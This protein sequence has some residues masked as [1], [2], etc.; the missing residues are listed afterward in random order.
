MWQWEI[1]WHLKKVDTKTSY[2]LSRQENWNGL[3]TPLAV[4]AWPRC[5]FRALCAEAEAEDGLAKSGVTTSQ[6]GQAWA[7]RRPPGLLAAARA[8][9]GLYVRLLH[10]LG[11]Y[12]AVLRYGLRETWDVSWVIGLMF[13]KRESS[14]SRD[15]KSCSCSS[16]GAFKYDI[17]P[18][19]G[20]GNCQK[21]VIITI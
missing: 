6:N 21:S 10:L 2:K 16:K 3:A 5:A 1:L 7:T 8:G 20:V 11:P 18:W 15:H 4:L 12:S 14:G 13:S 9:A 17:T 19:G